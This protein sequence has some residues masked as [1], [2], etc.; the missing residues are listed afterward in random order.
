M[1]RALVVALVLVTLWVGLGGMAFAQ[2]KAAQRFDAI[3]KELYPKAQKEGALIIYSQADVEDIVRLTD[4]FQKQFPGI[5]VG[6]LAVGIRPDRDP[7]PQR[8]PSRPGERRRAA[9]R[10]RC[11]PAAGSQG[12]W[13]PSSPCR[14]TTS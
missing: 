12:R 2:S 11:A 7:G 3:A 8:V 5:K 6:L 4:G 10:R 1:R 13:R 9:A 14:R